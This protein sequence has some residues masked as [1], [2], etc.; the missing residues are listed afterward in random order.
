MG[1]SGYILVKMLI[2]HFLISGNKKVLFGKEVFVDPKLQEI[3]HTEH[4]AKFS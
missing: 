2:Y 4:R 1:V 3:F